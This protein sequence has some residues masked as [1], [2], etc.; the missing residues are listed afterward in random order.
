MNEWIDENSLQKFAIALENY[1]I[2]IQEGQQLTNM[3]IS[4]K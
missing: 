3:D 1:L 2:S 4:N